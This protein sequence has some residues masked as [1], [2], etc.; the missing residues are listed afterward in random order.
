MSELFEEGVNLKAPLTSKEFWIDKWLGGGPQKEIQIPPP[1]K[2][3]GKAIQVG[4]TDDD[5][6]RLEFLMKFAT[7]QQV[8]WD[9]GKKTSSE[10]LADFRNNKWDPAAHAKEA[11]K[12]IHKCFTYV[13]VALRMAGIVSR[14]SGTAYAKDAFNGYLRL[15]GFADISRY[16]FY[17]P[18]VA[19]PGDV[20][21]YKKIGYSQR[22]NNVIKAHEKAKKEGKPFN[23]KKLPQKPEDHPGHIEIRTYDGFAS[24]YYSKNPP[25]NSSIYQVIGV[26][27]KIYDKKA[28]EFQNAFLKTL[29]HLETK[30][31]W[32]I[33]NT[34]INGNKHFSD[35]SQHPWL[36]RDT[37][38]I[39]EHHSTAAGAYQIKVSTY[40][41]LMD[42]KRTPYFP[43]Q[44]KSFNPVGQNHF[45][46]RL[47]SM[48]PYIPQGATSALSLI[49]QGKI[50]EAIT[51]TKLNTQWTSLPG[52]KE[53][54]LKGGMDEFITIFQNNLY[55]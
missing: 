14:L 53:C 4:M 23:E 12:S 3:E 45:A 34:P 55:K 18:Y 11:S 7:E 21:V 2:D 32:Q 42:P 16:C 35:M 29:A 27:R 26:F 22:E 28:E 50:R 44:N 51:E 40:L 30:S 37:R 49:R 10:V 6:R 48:W 17:D 25:G 19:L 54:H 36:D 13:K 46:L 1:T 15:E 38:T 20:I 33:L 41:G 39:P 43:I 31:D 24:D 8:K 47:L 5:R 9:Y 52:G